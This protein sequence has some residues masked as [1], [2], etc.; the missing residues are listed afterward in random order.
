MQVIYRF[1]FIASALLSGLHYIMAI[2][3]RG[4]VCVFVSINVPSVSVYI[5]PRILLFFLGFYLVAHINIQPFT[6]AR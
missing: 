5:H 6:Q 2:S 3:E 1:L 4:R